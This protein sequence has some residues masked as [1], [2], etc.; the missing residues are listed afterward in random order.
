MSGPLR[1]QWRSRS[2]LPARGSKRRTTPFARFQLRK[3]PRAEQLS[4]SIVGE[5]PVVPLWLPQLRRRKLVV[6]CNDVSSSTRRELCAGVGAWVPPRHC[7]YRRR[8]SCTCSELPRRAR[9]GAYSESAT[10]AVV[11]SRCDLGKLT[12]RNETI[13]SGDS[14]RGGTACSPHAVI[15]VSASTHSKAIRKRCRA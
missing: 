14:A 9:A 13:P 4:S 7:H 3:W 8:R 10:T 2:Y 5:A 12:D 6:T 15:R 1:R 11:A